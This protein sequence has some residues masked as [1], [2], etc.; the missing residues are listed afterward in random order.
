MKPLK[1]STMI[2]KLRTLVSFPIA[3]LFAMKLFDRI[4]CYCIN[5]RM[6]AD[7]TCL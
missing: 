5:L 7:S 6:F 3:V 4:K 2:K 1:Y